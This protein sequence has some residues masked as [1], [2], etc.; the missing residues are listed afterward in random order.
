MKSL[1]YVLLTIGVL[2]A[3]FGAFITPAMYD[4]P[5]S[6]PQVAQVNSEA[7][8]VTVTGLTVAVAGLGLVVGYESKEKATVDAAKRLFQ[9]LDPDQQRTFLDHW[10]AWPEG[11]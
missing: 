3:L 7:I 4:T 2:W 10:K 9:K 11:E 8:R 5:S 6:A 1:G